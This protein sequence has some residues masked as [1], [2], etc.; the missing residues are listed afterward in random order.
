MSQI[1]LGQLAKLTARAALSERAPGH[2]SG[3][4]LQ[5]FLEGRLVL[6]GAL[7]DYQE[8][9]TQFDSAWDGF[10]RVTAIERIEACAQVPAKGDPNVDTFA[11]LHLDCSMS[12]ENALIEIDKQGMR[13]ATF[14]ELLAYAK[15]FP[16]RRL[17]FP[18]FALGAV[19]VIDGYRSVPFI[20]WGKDGRDIYV[21]DLVGP[22]R[23][24]YRL[25]VIWK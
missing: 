23:N 6:R 22:L 3:E 8:L 1:S 7:V 13:P 12:M 19:L 16:N 2:I 25:L 17:E 21:H 20:R 11:L 15:R 10:D 24:D 4:L 14:E 9:K 5:A 18:I